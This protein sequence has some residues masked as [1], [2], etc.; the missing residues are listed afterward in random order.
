MDELPPL[1]TNRGG[2]ADLCRSICKQTGALSDEV[3][4]GVRNLDSLRVQQGPSWAPGMLAWTG[5]LP[6]T[7]QDNASYLLG[8]FVPDMEALP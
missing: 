2:A 6:C 8:G 3:G 5:R 1:L 4:G 7:P